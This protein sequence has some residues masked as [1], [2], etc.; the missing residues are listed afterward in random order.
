LK[1]V[2]S[3][4]L[5]TVVALTS[6]ATGASAASQLETTVDKLIGIKYRYG[7]TTTKGFDCSGF[8]TYVFN[9]VGIKLLRSSRE[10]ATMGKKVERKDLR[11]GDLVFFNTFGKRI[12]HVGIYLGDGKFVHS[13]SK[14]GVRISSMSERYYVKRYVTARRVL[15]EDLY[16]AFAVD[17]SVLE[18]VEVAVNSSDN[19]GDVASVP[20]SALQRSLPA[21]VELDEADEAVEAEDSDTAEVP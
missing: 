15:S 14:R 18:A 9:Q 17:K 1:R 5:A 16:T 6:F 10:Q 8:T 13:S 11:P 2:I 3:F 20:T 19:E 12:S 4:I 21:A 7:G